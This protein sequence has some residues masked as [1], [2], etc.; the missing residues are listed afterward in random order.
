MLDNIPTPTK[1]KKKKMRVTVWKSKLCNKTDTL[2]KM[3]CFHHVMCIIGIV[4]MFIVGHMPCKGLQLKK[5]NPGSCLAEAGLSHLSN[6]AAPSGTLITLAPGAV[7]CAVAQRRVAPYV[8]ITALHANISA[9]TS[10]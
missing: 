5:Q 1:K 6:K 10:L 7:S 3:T 4:K 8:G 2:S 9:F